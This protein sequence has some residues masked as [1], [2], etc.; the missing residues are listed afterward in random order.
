MS[1]FGI[2]GSSPQPQRETKQ[3]RYEAVAPS[4][5]KKDLSKEAYEETKGARKFHFP[6]HLLRGNTE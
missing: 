4:L 1:V 3:E 2:K 5:Q 6:D